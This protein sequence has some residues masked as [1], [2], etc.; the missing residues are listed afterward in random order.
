MNIVLF[1]FSIKSTSMA[2]AEFAFCAH[3]HY[4]RTKP[5]LSEQKVKKESHTLPYP[6]SVTQTGDHLHKDIE[7]NYLAMFKK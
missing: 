7:K 5:Y 2:I 3:S 4:T 6:C 1:I